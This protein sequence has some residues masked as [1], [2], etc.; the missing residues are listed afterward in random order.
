[1]SAD[2]GTLDLVF[3]WHMHQPDYRDR[4]QQKILLPWARLHALKDYYDMPAR[5]SRYEGI[6]QTF[7]LVPS[8][9]EQIE[10]YLNGNWH[11]T[12]L[13]LF[14]R[15]AEDLSENEKHLILKSF[16]L[17]PEDRMIRPYP[18]YASLLREYRLKGPSDV[19]QRWSAQ[20]WR[21]LQFWRQL[22]WIDPL[23]REQDEYVEELF[24]KGQNFE[25]SCK[26]GLLERMKFWLGES[27]S[28][29]KRLQEEGR[30]EVSVTP[31]YH[32][33]LPLLIDPASVR[34]AMPDCP[35]PQYWS[36]CPED[37]RAHV[38]KAVAFY[39]QRF[40]RKPVGMWPSEGSVSQ[41][42]ARLLQETGIKWI[43]SDEEIL[44]SSQGQS[45]R[46]GSASHPAAE[47]LYLPYATLNGQGPTILFRDHHLSD[48]IGF[49]Y[50]T[51]DPQDAARHLV[52]EVL[53][54]KDKWNRPER[55]LV[56]I[57]LDG[58]NCWEYYDRDGGPFLDALYSLLQ[59]QPEIRCCTV[60]E[61]L[62][63]REREPLPT[64]SAGSWINGN[65]FIWMGEEEDRKA[66]GM[67]GQ[68][69]QSLTT[70]MVESDI[71]STKLAEA[72]EELYVAE[73]SDWFWW[74][75]SSQQ[76]R[77]DAL[78][79][80]M[81]RLHLLRIYELI[82]M[83]APAA[84][85]N[86]VETV[87]PERITRMDPY[88]AASPIIDGQETHYYE[89]RAAARFEP[90]RQG[91]AMQQVDKSRLEEIRYGVDEDHFY[92]RVD[93]SIHLHRSLTPWRFELRITSPVPMRIR[94]VSTE[95][96][97][98]IQ[99][100][101]LVLSPQADDEQEVWKEVSKDEG[102]ATE[103]SI[104]EASLSWTILESH[105]GEV[106]S[107]FVGCPAG[108]DEIEIVPPLS[109]LYVIMPG[110]DRPGRHWFP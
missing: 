54:V 99:K 67:L 57:I 79:D 42:T 91:G 110:K 11:E 59:Q 88:L 94:F 19:I 97:I 100:G 5:L 47:R 53:K 89:W 40:G 22:T 1:M 18:R 58:E 9:V 44:A 28:V 74:F 6:H 60:S 55:P 35:V 81:F 36:K 98:K 86:P 70:A 12:E 83:E 52:G 107:F 24:R 29:Y 75:G 90:S 78:F 21:D 7:N 34:E 16:F 26:D 82:D 105:P 84:L 45:L 17:S 95:T 80:E 33:I 8:L 66:W 13:D 109:S 103:K 49:Q 108:K 14:L 106:L 31:Y 104:L 3:L 15:R 27:L 93:P 51:W 87:L 96:G 76:S 10:C 63:E 101:P 56:S 73:G 41:D 48:L 102:S 23:I 20:E 38:E 25:E 46:T 72:W 71:P 68:T 62:E 30:I 37:A 64:L 39:E 4:A 77:Q 69:R 85:H 65:F 50:A 32:P 43:A 2:P 92:L 61:A